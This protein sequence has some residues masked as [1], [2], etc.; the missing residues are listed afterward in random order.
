MNGTAPLADEERV[1]GLCQQGAEAI[2]ELRVGGMKDG[3]LA[4]GAARRAVD[5]DC[6]GAEVGGRFRD[7]D[8]GVVDEDLVAEGAG[9]GGEGGGGD[10]EGCE[11]RDAEGGGRKDRAAGEETGGGGADHE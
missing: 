8:L 4:P 7:E 1:A 6:A 10:G 5:V 2:R 11:K 3:G 9:L